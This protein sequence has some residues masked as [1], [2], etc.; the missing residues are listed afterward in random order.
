MSEKVKFGR[1]PVFFETFNRKPGVAKKNMHYCPGC[2]HGILHK[3]IA[4]AIDFHGIQKDT[5]FIAPVGCAVFSYY[6]FNCGSISVPHGRAP[7]VCTPFLRRAP[8]ACRGIPQFRRASGDTERDID[9]RY[10]LAALVRDEIYLRLR[11]RAMRI[12]ELA[13]GIEHDVRLALALGERLFE[14][15]GGRDLAAAPETLGYLAHLRVALGLSG[16]GRRA[17]RPRR[18]AGQFRAY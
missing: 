7:A 6:Y 16:E 1:S 12:G 11:H 9:G 10:R 13:P 15:H 8:R 14:R 4:E 5:M 18:R 17:R 3:L 2:G